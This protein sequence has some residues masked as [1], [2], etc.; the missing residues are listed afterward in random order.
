LKTL[1]TVGFEAHFAQK[2]GEFQARGVKWLGASLV[3]CSPPS[4]SVGFGG[5]IRL[6]SGN[7]RGGFSGRFGVQF[8]GDLGCFLASFWGAD[9][10]L[11]FAIF[12]TLLSVSVKFIVILN[13]TSN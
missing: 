10:V 8:G 11:I 2:K 9:L 7:F 12:A 6:A 13:S 3:G 4:I 1:V 5:D